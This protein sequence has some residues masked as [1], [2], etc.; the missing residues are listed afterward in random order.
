MAILPCQFEESIPIEKKRKEKTLHNTICQEYTGETFKCL[1]DRIVLNRGMG[2]EK[3]RERGE[4]SISKY[5]HFLD[6]S[7]ANTLSY[8]DDSV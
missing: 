2:K 5:G 8:F 1:G 7:Q 6:V 4:E 3:R